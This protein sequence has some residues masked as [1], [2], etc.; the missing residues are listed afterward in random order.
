MSSQDFERALRAW[1]RQGEAPDGGNDPR[2]LWREGR[3]RR[4]RRV[5]MGGAAGMG[6]MAA[7]AAGVL[8]VG[9]GLLPEATDTGPANPTVTAPA[10]TSE[11]D[12]ER[13][14]TAVP[15]RPER[16]EGTPTSAVDPERTARSGEDG[17]GG[18]GQGQPQDWGEP[19]VECSTG[20]YT[21]APLDTEGLPGEVAETATALVRDAMRCDEEA[22]IERAQ[23]DDTSLSFGGTPAAE[24]LAIPQEDPR[25][26]K[27]VVMLS[28][29]SWARTDE[30]GQVLYVWPAAHA[31]GATE[32]DW[33]E[34]VDSGLHSEQE[35]A[36][37]P[38]PG[39][40][41]FGWRVGISESGEWRFLIAGD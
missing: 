39:E 28:A 14:R 5:L 20:A 11:E 23:Q 8:A 40:A 41:Y 21:P 37:M 30:G 7:A 3:R 31:P 38:G 35:M 26:L 13:E 2:S 9:G 36:G 17:D 18:P 19:L 29:T 4:T 22:L 16:A 1:L 25:Y 34:V 6:L 32:E 24:A 15:T 12:P 10:P 27:L 33:Q